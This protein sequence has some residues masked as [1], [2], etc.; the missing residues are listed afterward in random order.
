MQKKSGN[1]KISSKAFLGFIEKFV[2]DAGRRD[3]GSD[4][5]VYPIFALA[6]ASRAK[7]FL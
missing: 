2:S 4:R 6:V 5:H 3:W 7:V 1:K